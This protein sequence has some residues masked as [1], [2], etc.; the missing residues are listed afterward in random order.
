MFILQSR[1]VIKTVRLDMVSEEKGT[2]AFKSG[3]FAK[4][5]WHIF[6]RIVRKIYYR[7]KPSFDLPEPDWEADEEFWVCANYQIRDDSPSDT[8]EAC[9]DKVLQS[10]DYAFGFW[11]NQANG[12]QAA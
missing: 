9:L 2:F 11:Q 8:P 7:V 1:T 6:R 5:R 10:L 12:F 4:P 3:Y